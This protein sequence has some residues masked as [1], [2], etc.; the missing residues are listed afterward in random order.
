[1]MDTQEPI[2][3][4]EWLTV[5]EAAKALHMSHVGLCNALVAGRIAGEKGKG[6]RWRIARSEVARKLA[7]DTPRGYFVRQHADSVTLAGGRVLRMPIV[8]E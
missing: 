6:G 4:P 1:M 3:L 2:E 8:T 7:E 5:A